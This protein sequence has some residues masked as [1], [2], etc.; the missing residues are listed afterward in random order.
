MPVIYM[1]RYELVLRRARSITRLK[2]IKYKL[3]KKT[4]TLVI[5]CTRDYL[6]LC[7]VLLCVGIVMGGGGGGRQTSP[8]PPT[9]L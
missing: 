4:G 1:A 7:C 5:L 8:P 9:L 3:Y 6:Q 2:T